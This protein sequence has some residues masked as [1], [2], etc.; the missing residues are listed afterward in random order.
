MAISV[1]VMNE[2]PV[3]YKR[4]GRLTESPRNE[5]INDFDYY[6]NAMSTTALLG[7]DQPEPCKW[8]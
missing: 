6:E 2:E 8:M 3:A 4:G 7:F 1:V 5:I